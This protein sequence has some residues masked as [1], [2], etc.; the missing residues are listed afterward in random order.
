MDYMK[1]EIAKAEA[2]R[3]LEATERLE[4]ERVASRNPEFDTPFWNSQAYILL[5]IPSRS[6]RRA[7]LKLWE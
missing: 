1:L 3:F 4:L 2:R 6:L 7:L 5:K